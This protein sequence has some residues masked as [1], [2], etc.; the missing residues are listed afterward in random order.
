MKTYYWIFLKSDTKEN[1][2]GDNYFYDAY[3]DEVK[4]ALEFHE[5]FTMNDN[6]MKI[7]YE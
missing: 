7:Y 6:G 5:L 4:T 1:K 2:N 3:S